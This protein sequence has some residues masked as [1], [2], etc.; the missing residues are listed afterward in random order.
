MKVEYQQEIMLCTCVNYTL[1]LQGYS[2]ALITSSRKGYIDI[3]RMLLKAGADVNVQN[4]VRY[5]KP[6]LK[7]FLNS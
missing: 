5:P 4:K 6:V 2:A 3:V 7:T 1:L